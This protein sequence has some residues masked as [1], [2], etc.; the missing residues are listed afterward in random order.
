MKRVMHARVENFYLLQF[1]VDRKSIA[2]YLFV[3]DII[4]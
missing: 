1:N 4:R 3:I 2:L